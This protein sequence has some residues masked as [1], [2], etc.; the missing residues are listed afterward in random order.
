[1]RNVSDKN[2]IK[3][4]ENTHFIFSNFTPES[5][6]PYEITWKNKYRQ[7]NTAHALRLPDNRVSRRPLGILNIYCFSTATVVTRTRLSI[8]LYIAPYCPLSNYCCIN[9]FRILLLS[10]SVITGTR[11][12]R[13]QLQ[14]HR[15]PSCK[16]NSGIARVS[17]YLRL[18]MLR[19]FKL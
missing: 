12:C 4:T 17:S 7:Y 10:G 15:F 9:L 8:T 16:M 18:K 2:L 14:M 6:A 5:R 19:I 1:M 3:K 11:C 13:S